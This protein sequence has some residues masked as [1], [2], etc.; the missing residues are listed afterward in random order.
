MVDTALP[1]SRKPKPQPGL[2]S[3]SFCSHPCLIPKLH[4]V[5]E[6]LL[7]WKELPHGVKG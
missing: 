4:Q 5:R 6:E 1:G 2:C 3:L 7:K